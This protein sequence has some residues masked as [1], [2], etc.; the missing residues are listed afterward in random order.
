MNRYIDEF[1]AHL[2]CA[3]KL[4]ELGLYPDGKELSESMATFDAARRYLFRECAADVLLD[5]SDSSTVGVFVG[6]G[7]N[8]DSVKLSPSFLRTETNFRFC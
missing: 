2:K 4:L 3:P 8:T 6:D 7:V 5:V 1:V